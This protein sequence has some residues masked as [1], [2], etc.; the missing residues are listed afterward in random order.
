M[1]R[2]ITNS[3][4]ERILMEVQRLKDGLKNNKIVIVTFLLWILVTES[5]FG[6][7]SKEW[8]FAIAQPTVLLKVGNVTEDDKKV[9]SL[10]KQELQQ[11]IEINSMVFSGISLYMDTLNQQISG[12]LELELVDKENGRL[13][14]KWT[15]K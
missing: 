8:D 13:I 11:D 9:I 6:N 5:F 1:K 2:T 4:S 10:N 15:I 7:G 14:K 3:E 12:K